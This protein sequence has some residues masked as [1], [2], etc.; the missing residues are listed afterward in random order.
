MGY[1]SKTYI[2]CI[3]K[4]NIRYSLEDL[5]PY[6][7]VSKFIDSIYFIQGIDNITGGIQISYIINSDKEYNKYA[8]FHVEQSPILTEISKPLRL[9]YRITS[10]KYSLEDLYQYIDDLIMINQIYM[11][12]RPI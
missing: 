10:V 9:I 3:I 6:I 7:G 1:P 4:I 12:Q 5:Y 8:L 2:N 11:T